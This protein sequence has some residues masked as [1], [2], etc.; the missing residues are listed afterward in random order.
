MT[1]KIQEIWT[2]GRRGCVAC[3]QASIYENSVV[4]SAEPDHI[5]ERQMEKALRR[6]FPGYQ[7]QISK[8]RG[9]GLF[10]EGSP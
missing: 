4:A 2:T 1:Y 6:E 10:M 5:T 9:D 7:F 3:I 8:G